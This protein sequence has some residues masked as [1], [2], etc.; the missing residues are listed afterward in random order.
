MVNGY[1]ALPSDSAAGLR[2][3]VMLRPLFN[4]HSDEAVR[5]FLVSLVGLGVD[6]GIAWALIA[7]AG[8]SDPVAALVG[9]SIATVTNY[10]GHEFWTFVKGEPRVSLLRF[11][12]FAGVVVFTLVVRLVVLDFLGPWLTGSGLNA[13]IRLGL[14]ATASLM[15]SFMMSRYLDFYR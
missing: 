12:A 7:F 4:K 9:F 8:A 11:M 3:T 2:M 13:P 14:A 1:A 5:F 10:F 6:I 15:D